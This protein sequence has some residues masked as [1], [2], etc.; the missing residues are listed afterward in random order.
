M[1]TETQ[2]EMTPSM[3]DFQAMLDATLAEDVAYEGNVMR[4]RVVGIEKDLAII[5]V[6]LK[7]E[8]RVPL[9][10]IL[11]RRQPK[12]EINVGDEVEVY[13]ERIENARR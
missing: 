2:N 4:G 1:S 10:R 13:L 6:G 11:D 3:D 7:M 5:D 8:G 12:S 9:K